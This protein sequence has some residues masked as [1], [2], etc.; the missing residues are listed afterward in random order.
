ML[1]MDL[2]KKLQ[3]IFNLTVIILNFD[4]ESVESNENR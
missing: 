1:R 4:L 2:E 3:T